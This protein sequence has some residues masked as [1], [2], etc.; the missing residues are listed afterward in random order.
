[1]IAVFRNSSTSPSETFIRDHVRYLAPDRTVLVCQEP[2]G[3]D[4]FGYPVLSGV[5]RPS[6]LSRL[7]SRIAT[8][9]RLGWLAYVREGMSRS[10]EDRVVKFFKAHN[11][12]AALV[13][14]LTISALFAR[15]CRRA[16]V[17]LYAH[18]HGADSDRDA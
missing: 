5:P 8:V 9:A 17:R 1:M 3:A 12:D 4:Q 18:A 15:A 13:E 14:Y 10:D 11:V 6:P 7:P 16:G 2:D